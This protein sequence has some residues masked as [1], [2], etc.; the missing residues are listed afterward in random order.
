[1]KLIM[2][3]AK[4]TKQSKPKITFVSRMAKKGQKRNLWSQGGWGAIHHPGADR[5]HTHT[6]RAS[7]S[8]TQ[9]TNMLNGGW[10]ACQ[11]GLQGNLCAHQRLWDLATKG[12]NSQEEHSNAFKP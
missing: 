9:R 1:M 2:T 11:D 10:Q 3:S 6:R 8:E 4:Y 7:P 12:D 5:L